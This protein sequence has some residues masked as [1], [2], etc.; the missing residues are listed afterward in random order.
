MDTASVVQRYVDA[1]NARDAEGFGDCLTED[2]VYHGA[3]TTGPGG[4][5]RPADTRFATDLFTGFPDLHI[6][7]V[8]QA[9]HGD[10]VFARTH[11]TGTHTG[12]VMG[13]A[14]SGARLEVDAL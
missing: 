9:L 10:M 4:D 1:L 14:P 7:V 6:E 13:Q 11:Q 8:E 5:E 12:S 3:G 2:F